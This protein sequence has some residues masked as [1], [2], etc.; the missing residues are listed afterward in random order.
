[1]QNVKFYN[2]NWRNAAAIGSCSHCT[3]DPSTDSGARTVKFKGLTFD[4][5]VTKKIRYETPFRAIY[6][7]LDGSLTGKGPGSWATPY[8]KHHTQ[9]E[10]VKDMA[11]YHGMICDNTV[12]VRRIAFQKTIPGL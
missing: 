3:H 9:K 12:Q 1:V 7:D 6:Y 8:F 2:F 4:K 5:S 11:V 10:C